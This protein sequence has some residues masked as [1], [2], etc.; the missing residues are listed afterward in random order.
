MMHGSSLREE[1]AG[2][3]SILLGKCDSLLLFNFKNIIDSNGEAEMVQYLQQIDLQQI[4]SFL[5]LI[6]GFL[7]GV[8]TARKYVKDG[9]K[10]MFSP[11]VE[12]SLKP[13][14]EDVVTIKKQQEE[15]S[16]KL[17]DLELSECRNYLVRFIEDVKS[18]EP[19]GTVEIERY[20]EVRDRYYA[21]GGNG[22]IHAAAEEIE[23]KLGENAA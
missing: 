19:V 22:Y 9:F 4:H 14:H 10:K 23:K 12:E 6:L 8:V 7:G 5:T 13:I 17:K 11:L 2:S 15:L 18:G 20:Y 3:R 21:L 16:N 1:Q